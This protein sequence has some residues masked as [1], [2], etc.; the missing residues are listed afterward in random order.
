MKK[1]L[2]FALS[3]SMLPILTAQVIDQDDPSNARNQVIPMDLIVQGSECLGIDCPNNPSFGFNTLELKE[4]NLRIRFTDT[5]TSASFPSRDWEI[6]INDSSNGGQNRF[7]ILDVDGGRVPFTIEAG[8]IA[9]ALYIDDAGDVGIGTDNPI[10]E[11]HAVDGNTPTLRLEQNGSSGFTPQT[12]DLAG[13]ETNFFIRDVT[14]GSKLP[15]RIKPGSP[16]NSIFIENPDGDVGMGTNSPDAALHVRRTDAST[17]ELFHVEGAG[18]VFNRIES[19][20]GSP[21]QIRIKSDNTANRRLL[22]EDNAGNVQ[23]QIS[24]LD[25][26]IVDF[27]SNS[28]ATFSKITA[29]NTALTASSSRS[30]KDNIEEVEIPDILDR[31]A[32][33]PVTKYNWK[34]DM[35]SDIIAKRENLGLIAQDFYT[36]LQ[37]GKD[38]EIN[39]QDVQMA[40]W[41][42]TQQL[43]K[44]DQELEELV[45]EKNAQITELEEKVV[46]LTSRLDEISELLSANKQDVLLKGGD[47]PVIGQ[48]YPNPY[49]N[50][51][52]IEY[53]LPKSIHSAEIQFNDVS[54]KLIK[55]VRVQTGKG[56]INVKAQDLP[57]GNYTY[58]LVVNGEIV[59]TKKMSLVR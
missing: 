16:D 48:N 27:Y 8:A 25:G 55:M 45:E 50:E 7:S 29:G 41:L 37:R 46:E 42:G 19:S 56:Q 53:Y 22:V 32:A 2:L 4:N 35:V 11:L 14:N 30:L 6:T 40:L 26:G 36:V 23:T 12:W 57:Q 47:R 13:N 21:V 54:G 17:N 3:L 49:L 9:D 59:D 28:A 43:H 24:L 10:V 51:T 20:D 5:S 39:G 15:F 34:R 31:I 1:I 33:V 18:T 52:V 58:S 38:T 44:K